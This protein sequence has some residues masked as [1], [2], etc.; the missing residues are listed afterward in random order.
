[1]ADKSTD[2]KSQSQRE[3]GIISE[4]SKKFDEGAAKEECIDDLRMLQKSHP[5]TFI[6]RNFYRI[7]GKY[8]DATWNRWFGTF[9]EFKRQAKLELTR[10]AH[11]LEKN[12]AKHASLD[13]FREYHDAKI[14]PYHNKYDHYLSK[15]G[16]R[17][18]TIAACS[19]LHDIELDLFVWSIFL[20]F[21]KQ[22]QPEVISLGGD[23]SDNPDFSK[24][25]VD[26][27]D[28]KLK[29]RMIFIREKILRPLR[30]ACPNSQI[31]FIVGNHD[32]RIFKVLAEQTPAMKVLLSDVLGLS[33]ADIY[34]LDEYDIN[35][36]CKV[37]LAAWSPTDIKDSLRENYRVYYNSFVVHHYMD[38]SMGISGVSGHNH[39]PLQETFVNIPMGKCTWTQMGAMKNTRTVYVP[40]N[41]KWTNSFVIAH[42]DTKK[43]L[44][45]QEHVIIPGDHC[46]LHGKLYE[47]KK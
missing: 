24:F 13:L 7:N 42:V 29:E 26:P 17:F 6:T 28:F 43:Y 15:K 37:D 1:M 35:L 33:L 40:G 4:L 44:V 36:V 12:I 46:V 10:G 8:S 3:Q 9:H 38:T 27:R 41:D 32:L 45:Q 5:L 19:D 2:K 21:C 30:E 23:I 11:G 14:L 20:D 47:R 39:R 31:D 25:V 34:G 22:A 18:K 16:G